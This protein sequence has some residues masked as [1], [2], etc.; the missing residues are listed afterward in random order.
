MRRVVITG[1]GM[2]TPFG[3]GTSVTWK[4]LINSNSGI[5]ELTGFEIK[6]LPSKIGGQVVSSGHDDLFIDN[7]I[8]HKEKRKIEKFIQ[9]AIS[10]AQEA[11]KDSSWKP[12][13]EQ[14]KSRTGVLVGSGIGGLDGIRKSSENLQNSPRRISP[15]FIPSCLINL[16]SGHISIKNGFTGPNHSVVT[17]CASGAHAVGDSARLIMLGDAD[18]MIAGGTE[19]ACTRFGIAGFSAMRALSTKFNNNPKKASRPWD[20]DRDGF[21]MSEGSGM[22]VLEELEHAKSRSAKIYAELVGYGLSGDGYHP[23]APAPDG[24]G[25]TRAMLMAIKNAKIEPEKID[26]VNAH[27][28]STPLGD[29]IEFNSV[30][31]LFQ[32]KKD[33]LF[34]SSTKSS[35]GH[36]LGASGAVEAIFSI[37]SITQGIIPPTLNLDNPS[38]TS[39]KINLVA[40]ESLEKKIKYAL[41]NSFGFGGTNASLIFRNYE[42]S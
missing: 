30:L 36:M 32:K 38:V 21:V 41:S 42:S 24:G 17:A 20:K 12:K 22:L 40:H 6:D 7:L 4:N 18:V 26:Y 34:M 14:E 33:T 16:A 5:R 13:N 37:L 35:I 10:S 39:E 31:N 19:A 27:G 29:E 25:G 11:I 28:T 2:C 8:E 23:T 15:F 9:F 1:I 3:Y